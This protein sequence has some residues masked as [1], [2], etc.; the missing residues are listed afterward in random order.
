MW[1]E[2]KL[3]HTDRLKIGVIYRSP[4]SSE[5]NNQKL[6]KLLLDVSESKPSHLLIMGDFNH[7]EIDWKEDVTTQSINHPSTKFRE[8]LRDC[9]LYQHVNR[10]THY[11]A[12][13]HPNTL[14]LVL[15]NEQYM[16]A[17]IELSAP[18]GKSHHCILNFMFNCYF[19]TE[20]NQKTSFMYEKA[21]FQSIRD[22]I[23][24]IDWTSYLKD[25]NTDTT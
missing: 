4:N 16:I 9:F 11:R 1:A 14:H 22:E 10:P 12:E 5:E 13:Q 3:Q 21:D 23:S 17:C 6:R 18:L 8:T 15:T 19:Y 24:S 7:P 25:K 2:I 20:R